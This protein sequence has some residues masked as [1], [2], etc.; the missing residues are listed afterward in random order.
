MSN[1]GRFGRDDVTAMADVLDP[2][3][4]LRHRFSAPQFMDQFRVLAAK[5]A[6]GKLAGL[7]QI[8]PDLMTYVSDEKVLHHAL[9]HMRAEGSHTAGPDGVRYDDLTADGG[10]AWCRA[11]RDTIRDG[12]YTPGEERVQRIPK[13]PGRGFRELVVQSVEDRVVARAAVEILQPLLDPLFDPRSFGFRPGKGPLRALATADGL[14]RTNE[15][16]VWVSADIRNAFPSVPIGR[17]LGLVRKYLP[18]DDLL[19]FVQ[20]A[21][22]PDKAAGLRQGSPLSPLLL[23]LYL[24]HVLDREWRRRRPGVPLLRFADDI[25]L[26]CRT[27]K[28]ARAAYDDLADLLRPAGFGLKEARTDAVR[29]LDRGEV[30]RWMGFGIRAGEEGLRCSITTEAWERLAAAFDAAHGKPHS[31]IAAFAS[32]IAWVRDK[33]PCYPHTVFD[34]AYERIERMAAGPGVRGDPR[35]TRGEGRMAAGIRSLASC[36]KEYQPASRCRGRRPHPSRRTR[37]RERPAGRLWWVGRPTRGGR[38]RTGTRTCG[39]DRTG[40]NGPRG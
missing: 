18:D 27:P 26:L 30:V 28:Q 16:T 4:L 37:R 6:A 40:G 11:V 15:L 19:S 17:L 33:A 8:A 29:R 5:A 36:A 3:W 10:W 34:R 24:H 25:L 7:R 23:N 9:D 20:A 39:A 12:D 1:N 38:R 22:R 13:G 35:K 21:T 2:K 32:I 14:Y 31:P